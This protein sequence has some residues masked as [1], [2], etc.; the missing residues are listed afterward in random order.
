ESLKVQDNDKQKK[1]NVAGP[2]VVNMVEHDNSSW[3]ND[4]R[5]KCKHHNT[6]A[7]PDNKPK[8]DD[9]AWWVDSKAT[10]HVCRDRYWFKI[11]KS[12]NDES[13]LHMGNESTALVHGRGCVDL[14]FS[15]GKIFL[16]FIVLHV[17]NIRKNLVSSSVLNN[18]G[19]KQAF[20]SNKFVLSKH[21]VFIG[22]G[23]L[24]NHMFMLNI[25]SDDIGSA[26][27]STSKLNDS[28]LWHARQGHVH[29]KRMQDMS[30]DGLILA[31]DMETK[32]CKTYML[33][34]ITKKPF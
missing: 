8:D 28:I 2:P 24:S 19:Y 32:K 12:L 31:F 17:P 13:I 33:T 10:M 26:I 16:L 15:S 11:Y 34:K 18:Y 29:S 30:K 27:M 25:V 7:D 9:V 4:N 22:F 21:G 3:Y 1:N 14:K 23:Y 5:G 20:E 6:K